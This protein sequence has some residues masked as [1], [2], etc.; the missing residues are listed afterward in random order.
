MCIENYGFWGGV[1][2][3]SVDYDGDAND[4]VGDDDNDDDDYD[5]DND[6]DSD[7]DGDYNQG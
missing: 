6:D 1:E 5:D 4:G 7:D 2:S 3:D